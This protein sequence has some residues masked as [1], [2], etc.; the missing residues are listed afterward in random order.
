M[1][2]TNAGRD[3]LTQVAIGE[4][5]DAF[6]NTNAHIGVG[7]GTTAFV[8]TQTD[9]VGANKTRK[10]MEATYPQRSDNVVTFKSIFSDV[11][12]NHG[13]K[14]WAVFNASTDGVMLNRKVEDNGTKASGTW[15]ITVTLTLNN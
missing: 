12:A 11:Q 6:N 10:A 13:W 5:I 15:A 7:D 4:T 2:L 3:Y 14:E 9:L 8:A 1:A